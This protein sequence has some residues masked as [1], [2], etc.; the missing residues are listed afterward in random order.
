MVFLFRFFVTIYVL[1]MEKLA[2]QIY[3]QW[4]TKLI[5]I[6]YI[7]V[8]IAPPIEYYFIK[9]EINYFISIFAFII[10]LLGM[11]MWFWA[12]KSLGKFW[13]T[14]IEIR[15][16]QVLIKKGPYR[17]FRHPHYLFLFCELLGLPLIANTF[18]SFF[19]IAIIYIP[20]I[21]LRIIFEEKALIIKFGNEYKEYKEEVWGL[22]PIPLFKKGVKLA[23]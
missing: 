23:K 17:Y 18:Y 11:T 9:R 3:K 6:F 2:G 19:L 4:I 22:F 13:S 21:T 8:F 1:K 20:L 16:N 5:F 15:K 10:Y 12:I 7:L 14:E